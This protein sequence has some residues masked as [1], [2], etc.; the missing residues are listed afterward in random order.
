MLWLKSFH[1][2]AIISWMAGLLYIW[3]LYVYHAMTSEPAVREQLQVMERKLL[4]AITTPAA[5]AA[6]VSGTALIVMNPMFLK[7]PWMHVKLTLVLGMFA[8]HFSALRYRHRLIADP[9]AT[10]HKRFRVYNEVPT[11]L[12]IGIVIMVIVKPWAR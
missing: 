5:I 1:V 11:L 3:R 10:A 7:Q 2:V 4:R 6:L 9:Q 12:M 8:S